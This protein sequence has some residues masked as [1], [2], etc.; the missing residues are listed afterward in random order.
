M[1][2]NKYFHGSSRTEKELAIKA[3]QQR[4]FIKS[5]LFYHNFTFEN[6]SRMKLYVLGNAALIWNR[7][8]VFFADSK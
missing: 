4:I 3:L 7:E 8:Q 5:L 6:R 1:Y 2:Q